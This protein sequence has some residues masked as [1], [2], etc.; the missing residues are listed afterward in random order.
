MAK[1]IIFGIQD[2]AELAHFYLTHD[3]EHDVVGFCVTEEYLP[4]ERKYRGLPVYS[5][6]DIECSHPTSDYH[7][8]APLS[9][10]RMNKFREDIYNKIKTKGYRLISYVS[11]K[12]TVFPEAIIGDNCFI[13]E[14]N[15]I[16]PFTPM[17]NNVVLW[18]GNHIGHHGNIGDHVMITSHVVISGH[19]TI[20]NNTYIGVNSTLKDNIHIREGTFIAMGSVLAKDTEPWSVYKGV[21]AVAAKI[22]STQLRF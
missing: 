3:S 15:T 16:Q 20:R 18:S 19:C 9:P 11:S 12:A 21:P 13:L 6:Q 2:F 14:D 17:G 4:P 10:R 22:L 5:F 8:F 1:I 7:F